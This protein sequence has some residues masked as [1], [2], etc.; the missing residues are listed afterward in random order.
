MSTT[1]HV[2]TKFSGNK[3][4]NQYDEIGTL[5]HKYPKK[6]QKEDRNMWF[7]VIREKY[8][9]WKCIKPFKV[10]LKIEIAKIY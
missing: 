1:A 6:N 8:T 5:G 4:I 3:E 9:N 7:Y 2:K 10:Y